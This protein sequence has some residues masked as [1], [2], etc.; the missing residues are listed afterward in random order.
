M[1][2]IY[3]M[4]RKPVVGSLPAR[5]E[6]PFIK[7]SIPIIPQGQAQLNVAQLDAFCDSIETFK[8]I[9]G[10]VFGHCTRGVSVEFEIL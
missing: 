8:E 7:I 9:C 1:D 6:L 2:A 5:N 10:H 3:A 4:N